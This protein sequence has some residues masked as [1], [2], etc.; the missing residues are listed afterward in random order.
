MVN[1]TG[2][3]PMLT[4]CATRQHRTTRQNLSLWCHGIFGSPVFSA[5]RYFQGTVFANARFFLQY[6]FVCNT[7]F[8][9]APSFRNGNTV[10][11]RQGNSPVT[12]SQQLRGK[13][14]V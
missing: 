4:F 3:R 10:P 1:P 11:P 14:Q 5:T 9:A 6:G 7:V 13:I 12:T 8:K 2:K